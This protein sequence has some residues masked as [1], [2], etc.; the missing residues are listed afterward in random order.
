MHVWLIL[1]V[2]PALNDLNSSYS[3][4]ASIDKSLLIRDTLRSFKSGYRVRAIDYVYLSV[5]MSETLGQTTACKISI[6]H[7][8]H[9]EPVP[10]VILMTIV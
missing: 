1:K 6:H 4:V 5:G 8:I 2:S 3:S 9:R 7:A 10:G